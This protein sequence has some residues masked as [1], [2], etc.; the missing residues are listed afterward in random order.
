[1]T[2]FVPQAFCL[3]STIKASGAAQGAHGPVTLKNGRDAG[4]QRRDAASPALRKRR[5]K[6]PA[7]KMEIPVFMPEN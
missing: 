1:M 6:M 2:R 5:E 4:L 3:A 7:V